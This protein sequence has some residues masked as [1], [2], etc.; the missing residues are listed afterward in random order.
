MSVQEGLLLALAGLTAGV[1]GS[2]AGL[3]SLIS[4][5]ALLASGLP[6]V[7]AN[8]TNTV[9]LVASGM[10]SAWGSK[11]ELGNQGPRLRRLGVAALAGGAI[12][13]L[14]LLVTPAEAFEKVVP[15]LIG[16]ASLVLLVQPRPRFL[17][18]MHTGG[19]APALTVAVLL[20]AVYGGYFGAASGVLLF[21]LLLAATGET[22]ATSNALKNA[23]MALANCVA[24]V[25]FAV[26]ADVRWAAALPL[27]AGFLAGGR[28]GPSVV[29]RAP[30]GVLRVVIAVAGLGLAVKLG[31]DAYR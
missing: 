14:L 27:A 1:V 25:G 26:F 4:Y 31:L 29:R 6:P 23:L 8:V 13:G 7:A 3:A 20:V 15:L 10:G 19:D 24:A 9:A 12:G 18:Q 2:V 11:P 5:P 22:F 21:A 28:L 30:V 16:A 17:Q